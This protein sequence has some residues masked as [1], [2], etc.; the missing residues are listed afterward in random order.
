MSGLVLLLRRDLRL[1]VRRPADA[2]VAVAFFLL[3]ACLFP[4]GVG[5]E[6]QL[7]AR[8]ASGVLWSVALLAVLLPLERLFLAEAEDGTLDR[9]VL[10]PGGALGS[11]AGLVLA[12]AAAHWLT[13]CLPLLIASP[14]VA[15]LL[16]MSA[17]GYGGLLA[18]LALG[19]PTLVLIGAVAAALS[20][21]ARRGGVLLALLAL[22]LQVPVL[23]FGAAAVEAALVGE[24]IT[25]HLQVLAGLLLGAL[26]LAPVAGGA[27][28]KLA[29]E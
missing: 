11:L 21:G 29:I 28:L 1:A 13:V 16:N 2:A 8:I 12:K 18:A 26:A 27:A 3:A 17:D 25:A 20:T 6:P 23:I 7:L 14:V 19:T 9:L 24:P 5:A 15:L 4:F 22:P 10:A